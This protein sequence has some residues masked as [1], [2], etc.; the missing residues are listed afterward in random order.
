ML[1]ISVW[2]E[3]HCVDQTDLR[4]VVLLCHCLLG[5]GIAGVHHHGHFIISLPFLRFSV[6]SKPLHFLNCVLS[7]NIELFL[8]YFSQN[9][10]LKEKYCFDLVPDCCLFRVRKL[11]IL[12]ELFSKLFSAL[13]LVNLLSFLEICILYHRHSIF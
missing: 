2:L 6:V 1:C 4:Y 12:D 11:Q 7:N 9:M 8:N 10:Y 3:A 13:F 5:A